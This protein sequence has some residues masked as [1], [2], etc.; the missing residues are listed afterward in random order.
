MQRG[1]FQLMKSVNKSIILNKIRTS[2][3]ISRAQIAKDTTLTPPTVS[4]IVKELIDQGIVMESELGK[5]MGGRKP[6]MLHINSDAYY[7][8]GVDAG[9][10]TVACML[11]NLSGEVFERISSKVIKPTT[12]TK[13]LAVIKENIQKILH[14]SPIQSEKI[15]GIGVAMHGVVNVKDGVSQIAPNLGLSNIPIKQE[16]EEAFGLTVRVENDARAM[17]LGESWF[18]GHGG[19]HSMVAVNIGRG[20]GSGIIINKQLYHGAEDI[21]GEIGHMTIDINGPICDCGNPG[22]LQTFITGTAIADRAQS[23][24]A[25]ENGSNLTGK[26]VFERAQHGERGYIELLQE[27]GIIIGIGLINLIHLLNPE[28]IVLGGGVM[29]GEK[30]IFPHIKDTIK[31]RALTSKAKETEITITNLGDDATLLGAVALLL[32]ELFNER[33]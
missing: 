32:V 9:P 10:E 20:V 2:E 18:G 26:K 5:S 7:V 31:Q 21:A 19:V 17:A 29:K 3:P 22:C 1:T 24:L 33:Q 25:L 12:N 13:F 30:F 23:K 16:L 4:S 28:K 6:T 11:T 15:I 14:T 8:V 27:T